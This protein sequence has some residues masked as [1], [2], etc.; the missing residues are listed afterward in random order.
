[1]EGADN[2]LAFDRATHAQMG[3]QV[4][5]VRIEQVRPAAFTAIQHEVFTEVTQRLDLA[6]GEF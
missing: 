5:A 1:V 3:A 4:W 2:V 6:R